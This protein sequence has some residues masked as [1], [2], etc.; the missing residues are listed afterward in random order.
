MH[1]RIDPPRLEIEAHR[2]DHFAV[3]LLLRRHRI[4]SLEPQ[5]VHRVRD[6]LQPRQK[7]RELPLEIGE[8]RRKFGRA[9]ARFV[10]L[11]QRV[12]GAGRVAPAL[13][14]LAHKAQDFLQPRREAREV[15]LAPRLRPSLARQRTRARQ[16]LHETHRQLRR[17]VVVAAPLADIRG[18]QRRLLLVGAW[19][20]MVLARLEPVA[21]FRRRA[22]PMRQPRK[23]AELLRA[24]RPGL[25]R[26]VGFL[27]P[28]QQAGGAVVAGNFAGPLQ[29]GVIGV[30]RRQ[31]SGAPRPPHLNCNL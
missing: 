22:Q 14:L 17:A 4:V 26:H 27:V 3:E 25:R 13:G 20:Q 31:C 5:R 10:A 6:L 11:E 12:V 8:D 19:W 15:R 16:V 23:L 1:R 21:E 9:R 18:A 24:I 2:L 29:E 30:H 28:R 7:R